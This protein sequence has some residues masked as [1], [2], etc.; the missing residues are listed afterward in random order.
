MAT[1]SSYGYRLMRAAVLDRAVFEEIEADRSALPQAIATVVLSSLA[2]G[3]GSGG[4][5]GVS[6]QAFAAYSIAAIVSWALWSALILQIGARLLPEA[7]TQ[8]SFGELLRTSGFAA[9]PGL[10]MVFAAFEGV[11]T[12]IFLAAAVWMLAAM[13][14]AV[15]QALDYR[16]TRHAI[17]V[18][19]VAWALAVLLPLVFALLFTRSALSSP[20][21]FS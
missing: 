8:T 13:V 7:Q 2:A 9:A 17:T 4:A 14:V 10:L 18:C 5:H 1:M 20:W 16:S 6:M 11:T 3:L 19:A 21:R 12:G 15:R